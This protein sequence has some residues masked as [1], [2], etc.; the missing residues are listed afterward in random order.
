MS[1]YE[2]E[3]DQI[4]LTL[5]DDSELLCDVIATFPVTIKGTEQMYVALLPTDAGEDAEIFL[6]RFSEDGDEIDIQNIEDDEEFEIV[7]VCYEIEP[8]IGVIDPSWLYDVGIVCEY[9]NGE[10]FWCHYKSDYLSNIFDE[11]KVER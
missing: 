11:W 5:E 4:T 1:N 6:Y 10:R 8:K 2:E 7:G 3:L 9:K